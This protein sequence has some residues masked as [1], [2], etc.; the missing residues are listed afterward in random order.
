MCDNPRALCRVRFSLDHASHL[1]R[2]PENMPMMT[3]FHHASHDHLSSNAKDLG[4]FERGT[5]VSI[6]LPGTKTPK[7]ASLYPPL[8]TPPRNK[9]PDCLKRQSFEASRHAQPT[10]STS[11]VRLVAAPLRSSVVRLAISGNFSAS[12]TAPSAPTSL[13]ESP[14]TAHPCALHARGSSANKPDTCS[15]ATNI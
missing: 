5:V 8:R 14:T 11:I 7:R 4:K 6:R 10:D 2:H 3:L 9:P 15:R 13:P 1:L 12:A